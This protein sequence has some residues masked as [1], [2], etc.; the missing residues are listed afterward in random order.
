MAKYTAGV[1]QLEWREVESG[2][3]PSPRSGLQAAMVDNVVYVTGGRDNDY[4]HLT[5]ILS[6]DPT[7]ESWEEAGNLA[8]ARSYHAAVAVSSSMVESG[9]LPTTATPTPIQ[10]RAQTQIPTPEPTPIPTQT[11]LTPLPRRGPQP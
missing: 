11:P 5:S 10:Q 8:V 9:C 1:S 2:K 6:W 4:N 7:S 3:L